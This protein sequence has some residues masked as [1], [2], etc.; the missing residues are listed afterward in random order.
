MGVSPQMLGISRLRT[1]SAWDSPMVATVSISRGDR[2]KRLTT[3][4]S[5]PMVSTTTATTPVTS[6]TK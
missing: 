4:I 3:R 2:A 1:I 5:A 6:P